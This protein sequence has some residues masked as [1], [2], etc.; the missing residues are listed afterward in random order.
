MTSALRHG[1]LDVEKSFG[2]LPLLGL[3]QRSSE[4][5]GR[6]RG[7][8]GSQSSEEGACGAGTTGWHNGMAQRDG[9]HDLAVSPSS[10]LEHLLLPD[11][12]LRRADG[13]GSGGH[14]TS[15]K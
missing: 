6:G 5:E 4:R 2:L 10:V 15:L 12:V 14:G 11:K 3:P 1:N 13:W 9:I 7:D 8:Q